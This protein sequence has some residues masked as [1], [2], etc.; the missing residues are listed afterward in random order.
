MDD[1]GLSIRFAR[2][3][4]SRLAA[5]APAHWRRKAAEKRCQKDRDQELV[6]GGLLSDMLA[7]LGIDTEGE[8]AIVE[9][10]GGKPRLR[11]FPDVH[12]SMSH[13]DGLVMCAV[14]DRPVGCDVER[15]VPLDDD[16]AR[17]IGSIEAWTLKEAAFKCGASAGKANGFPAPKGYCAAVAQRG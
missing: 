16:L 8:L 4:D 13:T 7:E 3:D 5:L 14:S 6:V 15:I 11:D 12:F 9:E 1:V 10:P 2:T 17:E